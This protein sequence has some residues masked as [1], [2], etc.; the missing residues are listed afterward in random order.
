M[1]AQLLFLITD[2][3]PLSCSSG[4]KEFQH[5]KGLHNL[6]NSQIV[7]LSLLF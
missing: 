5:N 3:V 2:S 4:L 1:M 7:S 6:Y